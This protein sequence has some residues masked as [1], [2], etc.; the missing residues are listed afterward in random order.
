[1]YIEKPIEWAKIICPDGLEDKVIVTPFSIESQEQ[2]ELEIK[3]I[4]DTPSG[5]SMRSF[6]KVAPEIKKKIVA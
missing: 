3:I 6:D 4:E 1:M 2:R 5:Y